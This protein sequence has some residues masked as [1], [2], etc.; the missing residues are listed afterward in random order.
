MKL[1][2]IFLLLLLFRLGDCDCSPFCSTCAI[3]NNPYACTS[4]LPDNSNI[5]IFSCPNPSSSLTPFI[6]VTAII[7]AIHLFLIVTGHGIYRDIFENIQLTSLINW[8]YG[9]EQGT[10][11]L[12]GTNLAIV[13]N[14]SFP[15]TFGTQFI[16]IMVILGV[17]WILLILV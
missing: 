3:P 2:I 4:C 8:R 13:R 11:G 12:Q 9:F 10:L 6:I 17:F 15:E 7:I 1:T 5:Y 14:N 16:A